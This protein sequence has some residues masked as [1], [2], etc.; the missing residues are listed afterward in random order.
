MKT[1]KIVPTNNSELGLLDCLVEFQEDRSVDDLGSDV[2][3]LSKAIRS[4]VASFHRRTP[5]LQVL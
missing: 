2:S 1:L 3:K 4:H 5:E